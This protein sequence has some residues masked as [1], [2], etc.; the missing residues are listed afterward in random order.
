V[1]KDVKKIIKYPFLICALAMLMVAPALLADLL[2]VGDDGNNGFTEIDTEIGDS[3][4]VTFGDVPTVNGLASNGKDVFIS[5]YGGHSIVKFSTDGTFTPFVTLDGAAGGAAFDADGNLFVPLQWSSR[6]D[7]ISPN[8]KTSTV[9]ATNVTAP[10]QL[11]VDGHGNLFC[12]DQKAGCIYK[13]DPDGTQTT[14]AKNVKPLGLAFD[15]KGTL[16]ARSGST[17]VKF[18]PDGTQTV[19][20]R[21]KGV[22]GLAFDS[23]GN[24]FASD[25]K[26]NVYKFE[27]KNGQ[28]SPK[29]SLF[30]G[31]LGRNFFITIMPG[32]TKP[33]VSTTV[34]S[35]SSWLPWA[36]L[37]AL[38]LAAI[39]IAAFFALRKRR[40]PS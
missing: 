32:R 40:L 7:K 5:D 27:D 31:D 24:L 21:T 25:G 37:S 20:A 34:A 23:K 12:A 22:S 36:A 17:I 30:A 10:V 19:F 8:G 1:T 14:F 29:P 11:A 35:T 26:G 18:A 16:F 13:F 6:I 38:V 4:A 39:G 28:L 3:S 15:R 9:F 2:F 33:A